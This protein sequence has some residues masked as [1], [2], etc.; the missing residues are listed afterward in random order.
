MISISVI[1]NCFRISFIMKKMFRSTLL[2]PAALIG[3][4]A[5]VIA[6]SE[7]PMVL[8]DPMVKATPAAPA[9]TAVREFGPG[10][11]AVTVP[12]AGGAPVFALY[13]GDSLKQTVEGWAAKMGWT[14]S[15]EVKN[16][17]VVGSSAQF[18]GDLGAAMNALAGALGGEVASLRF[19]MYQ[20]NQVIRVTEHN[21]GRKE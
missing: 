9:Y 4:S 19:E 5:P 14:V 13:S 3:F 16:D 11:G 6:A 21:K 10:A 18:S 7:A 15:W 2:V 8:A 20:G 1:L 17:Y 12:S